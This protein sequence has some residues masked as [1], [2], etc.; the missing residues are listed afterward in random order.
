MNQAAQ[1]LPCSV[2]K[3]KHSESDKERFWRKVNKIDGGCWEWTASLS[4][5]GYGKFT[6]NNRS[7]TAHR[8]S[9]LFYH[10]YLPTSE[11]HV[12]H[13]CDNPK[14]VNP[15]HLSAGTAHENV[16]DMIARGRKAIGDSNG[17]RIVAKKRASGA[18]KRYTID[19]SLH[20]KGSGI[21]SAKL[22]EDSVIFI[23]HEYAFGR[24]TVS[25]ISERFGISQSQVGR[26]IKNESWAHIEL[27]PLV[28]EH[29]NIKR[30]SYLA[31]CEE[32]FRW[33]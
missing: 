10:G 14:C 5:R 8:A 19:P 9:F 28:D 22:T 26:I 16:M 7:I 12:R 32:L 13:S 31:F 3:I 21:A 29:G 18:V 6:L 23:R 30:P 17:S 11:L 27:T 2:V 20:L 4:I 24:M 1:S 25:E 33:G 15:D